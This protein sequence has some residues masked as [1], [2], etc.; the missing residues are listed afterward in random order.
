MQQQDFERNIVME[1][2]NRASLR[3]LRLT[4]VSSAIAVMAM[5]IAFT[6][7]AHGK[8]GKNDS[9]APPPK[10]AVDTSPLKRDTKLTTSFAPV[11]KKVSPS[12]VNIFISSTPKNVSFNTPP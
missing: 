11:V 7:L 10:V 6:Q 3:K 1:N 12:V 4:L 2:S 8:A 5:A 9:K